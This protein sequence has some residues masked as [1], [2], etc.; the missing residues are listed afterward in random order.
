MAA[1]KNNFM[2]DD[3]EFC[4]L[5]VTTWKKYIKD[6]PYHLVEDRKELMKSKTGGAYY[7]VVQTKE[8]IQKALRD[9]AKDVTTMLENIKRLEVSEENKKKEARGDNEVPEAM[10]E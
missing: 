5:Q 1:K 10:E 4:R 3:L 7:A 6:N 8:V 2:S 9:T